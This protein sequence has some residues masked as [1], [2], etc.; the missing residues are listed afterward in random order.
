MGIIPKITAEYSKPDDPPTVKIKQA[1]EKCIHCG[2]PMNI[3]VVIDDVRELVINKFPSCCCQKMAVAGITEMT[4][5][6]FDQLREPDAY[7]KALEYSQN[8]DRWL[9]FAGINGSGKTHLA[10]AIIHKLKNDYDFIFVTCQNLLNFVKQNDWD[11]DK[12]KT[13]KILVID[14][15]GY[16]VDSDWARS[17]LF[18]IVSHREK[19]RMI[20]IFTTNFNSSELHAKLG[21]PILDRILG[22]SYVIKMNS[23][24][25]YR[26]EHAVF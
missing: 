8:P 12:F 15:L 9:L 26:I 4:F 20:T 25:S 10:A 21:A 3:E 17:V 18:D 1:D 16:S 2:K 6:N 22:I 19:N 13:I 5:D 7:K 23:S 24:K 14:E 11:Y